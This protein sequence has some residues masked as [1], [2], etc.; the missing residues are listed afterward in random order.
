MRAIPI[1]RLNLSLLFGFLLAGCGPD[2]PV[3]PVPIPPAEP[4][5]ARFELSGSVL[6]GSGVF[7]AS[8]AKLNTL[9][10]GSLRAPFVLA[11]SAPSMLGSRIDRLD[12][13]I[14]PYI[15]QPGT[16]RPGDC[17]EP[18]DFGCFQVT[19]TLGV[20]S[21]TSS[22]SAEAAVWLKRDSSTIVIKEIAPDYVR[23][24]FAGPAT[25][26]RQRGGNAAQVRVELTK[27]SVLASR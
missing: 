21:S 18:A 23:A 19:I 26:Q 16:Y 8:G 12:I 24:E 20:E 27:G 5:H 9:F 14:N 1:K 6:V 17:P 11:S 7:Q 15:I 3:Q 25:Y 22:F 2:A 10:M 13:T 4:T